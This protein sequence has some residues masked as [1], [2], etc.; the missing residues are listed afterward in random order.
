MPGWNDEP[1]TVQ[2]PGGRRYIHGSLPGNESGLI[3]QPFDGHSRDD[4]R[5]RAFDTPV[6]QTDARK[7]RSYFNGQGR[8]L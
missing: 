1:V 5:E 3:D 8:L 2:S 4:A 6:E 7:V